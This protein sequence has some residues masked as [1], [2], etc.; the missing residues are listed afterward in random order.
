MGRPR[1]AVSGAPQGSHLIN[2]RYPKEKYDANATAVV[3][4]VR[5]ELSHND[6]AALGFSLRKKAVLKYDVRKWATET[7]RGR[8][9]E[10]RTVHAQGGTFGNEETGVSPL[11]NGGFR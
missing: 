4:H 1:F 11:K 6:V 9:D 2:P 3:V 10:L 5:V 7:V 8:M